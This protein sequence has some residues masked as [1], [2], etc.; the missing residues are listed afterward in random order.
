VPPQ[1]GPYLRLLRLARDT[2]PDAIEVQMSER[3]V[4]LLKKR[5]SLHGYIIDVSYRRGTVRIRHIA[6]IGKKR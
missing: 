6:Q 1:D 2:Y 4:E 3:K 5:A